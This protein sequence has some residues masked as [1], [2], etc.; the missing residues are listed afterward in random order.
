MEIKKYHVTRH[1]KKHQNTIFMLLAFFGIA[2]FTIMVVIFWYQQK[3]FKKPK[4]PIFIAP[5][6]EVS[7]FQTPYDVLLKSV[8][9]GSANY[10]QPTDYRIPIIM[11]HYVEYVKDSG[12]TI[13]KKL[14]IVPSLFEGQLKA[15]NEANYI[16]YFVKDIPSIFDGSIV[17]A[18]KSIVLTFDDGYEDFYTSAFPILKKYQMKATIYIIVDLI[19]KKGFLNDKE[20]SE[21][22]DSGLV[23]IGSHTLD[24]VY[25]KTASQVLA[26]KQ[27]KESK[28]IL[29]SRFKIKVETFAYPTGAFNQNT[30]NLVKDAGYTAALSVIP[31][32]TQSETN[33]FYLYRIRPGIFTPQ[34]IIKALENYKK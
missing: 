17:S 7:S 20:I 21:L 25:L 22:I 8:A 34:T 12:D 10:K 9:T 19:N 29:E 2:I 26:E 31:G 14:D 13:R 16:S 28:K 33:L 24:H 15:L 4:Q 30:I 11:Y 23:E 3:H 1:S 6:Y 18:P 32:I 27:I 5:T